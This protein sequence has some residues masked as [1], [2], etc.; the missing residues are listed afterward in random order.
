M[1]RQKFRKLLLLIS[2]LLFPVTLY[3]F[4]PVLIIGAGL[5]GIINGSFIVFTAMLVLSVFFGRLFCG[6]VCPGGGIQEC[7]FEVNDKAPKQGWRNN[8]KYVIW[9]LWI[10]VVI[11]CYINRKRSITVN[12]FWQTEYGISV[13]E[14]YIYAVYYGIVLLII[15]PALLFG[16]RIFCHYFCWM[17]PFMVIGSRIGKI[18]RIPQLQISAESEKCTS[19][20]KCSKVCPM[21]LDVKNMVESGKI[22]D[23]ECILCGM[24][25][26]KCPKKVLNYT[27]KIK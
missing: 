25:A 13:S 11:I 17:A 3:Y 14:I 10:A 4:S 20:G 6:Y 1:K 23:D 26:D 9:I 18:L 12:F 19:C 8:I 15:L 24:C 21:S 7:A 27:M 22:N 5:E 2:L 16:K